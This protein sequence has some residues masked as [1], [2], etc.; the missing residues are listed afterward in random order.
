MTCSSCS[1]A[2]ESRLKG[3]PGVSQASVGLLSNSAEVTFSAGELQ[4]GAICDA[5]M[6]M[7]YSAELS[8]V[9]PAGAEHGVARLQVS[10]MT[11]SACCAAVE[12]T[13]GTLP[14]VANAVV[15]LIQQQ[16]RV[17]YDAA[18]VRPVSGLP[19]MHG[20][21]VAKRGWLKKESPQEEL[22]AAVEGVGFEAKLL[23]SGDASSL[24]LRVGGMTCASCSSAVEHALAAMPGVDAASVSLLT[25]T[26]EV[27]YD[28][29]V[30][31]ARDII[32][33]VHALGYEA[34]LVEVDD[35]SA[36]MGE[37]EK[38]KRFWRRKVLW[39]LLFSV[40]VFFPAMVFGNV[41]GGAI[42]AGRS[43]TVGGFT[44]N[45]LLQWALTTPVQFLVGW[46][47]HADALRVLRRGSANMDVLV[48][49]GT[50]AAYVY[51]VISVFH[52]RALY[53]AGIAVD[54]MGFF[55][56]SAL[57]IT[58]ISLGKFLRRRTPRAG[59]PRCAGWVVAALVA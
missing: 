50:N 40:P 48:S 22:V 35:I 15:S 36:G 23:G 43:T 9:R 34:S 59:R 39:S 21:P 24:R 17:E 47:F 5:V 14:G 8:G 54:A 11:C 37:R 2:I 58:F 20:A 42:H 1:S 13:L 33:A 7:G 49:L 45:E 41:P 27:E 3:L 52:R 31:G 51:S 57:L 38:E 32:G 18:I 19:F 53:E 12:A 4:P 44:I 26:A 10:G 16:A 30:V 28:S 56:T 29:G 6:E 25:N 46:H 55:E